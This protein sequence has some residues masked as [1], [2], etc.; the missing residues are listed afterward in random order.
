MKF[1]SKLMTKW[2]LVDSTHE[3]AKIIDKMAAKMMIS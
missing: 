1:S 3:N 2:R